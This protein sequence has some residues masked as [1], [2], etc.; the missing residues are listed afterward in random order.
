[1]AGPT[2]SEFRSMAQVA[3]HAR[4]WT[5]TGDRAERAAYDFPAH[6][7][8]NWMAALSSSRL[9]TRAAPASDTSTLADCN[10]DDATAR[11]IDRGYARATAMPA[12]RNVRKPVDQRNAE[13]L[14]AVAGMNPER[15]GH[16]A[17]H[18]GLPGAGGD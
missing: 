8:M 17:R 10:F 3:P 1:M 12:T 13:R 15:E 18:E 4:G 7:G 5:G 16:R 6:A 14:P 9:T 11:Q 2:D